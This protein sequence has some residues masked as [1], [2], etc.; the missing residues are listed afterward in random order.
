[1]DT[2]RNSQ[3]KKEWCKETGENRGNIIEQRNIEHYLFIQIIS[4]NHCRI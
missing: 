3:G 2:K 1:M 4:I